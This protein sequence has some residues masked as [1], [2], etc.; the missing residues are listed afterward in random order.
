[1]CRA[2]GL[3]VIMLLFLG[4]AGHNLYRYIWIWLAAFQAVAVHCVREK[5]RAT[6][7]VAVRQPYRLPPLTGP[8]RT[9]AFPLPRPA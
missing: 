1:V 8:G 5:A 3:A 7:R 4:M 2:T 9:G 6:S